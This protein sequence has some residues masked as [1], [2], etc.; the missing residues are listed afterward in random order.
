MSDKKNVQE[1]ENSG[2]AVIAKAKDFWVK[3]SKLILITGTT[4]I[5]LVGG[6]F[7]YRNFFQKP[8]EEKATDAMFKAEDYYRM[9]SVKLALNGDG[10]YLGFLK[11]M[12]KFSGTDAANLA[13]FYAGSCYLKLDDNVNAI[14][15]LK[16]FSTDAK[17]IQQRAYKLLG[18]AYADQGNAAEALDYYKK[19]ARHFEKDDANSAEAL[20]LAAYL[21][22]RVLKNQKEAIDLYKELKEKFPR[23]Q[24]G[25]EADTYLAQLGVYNVN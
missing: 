3:Y 14:K 8:K 19:A 7:I 23:T 1:V 24:Q 10:Q 16:K 22:D 5:V 21:A 11:I 25:T 9:D 15:H 17:Q 20:F 2:E 18:D 6:F 4:L 13:R 12:D